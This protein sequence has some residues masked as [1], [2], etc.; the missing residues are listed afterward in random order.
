MGT[1][2]I[3]GPEPKNWMDNLVFTIALMLSD[4]LISNH[5]IKTFTLNIEK[6]KKK[7]PHTGDK[8]SLDRCG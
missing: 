5:A 1:I 3:S 6:N 2:V 4:I 7:I 8:A